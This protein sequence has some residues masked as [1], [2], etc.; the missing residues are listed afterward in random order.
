LKTRLGTYPQNTQNVFCKSILSRTMK[1]VEPVGNDIVSGCVWACVAWTALGAASPGWAQER[2]VPP[3]GQVVLPVAVHS[4]DGVSRDLK[5]AEQAWRRDPRNLDLA[6]RYAREAFQVGMT[7]GD[8]RWFGT[9]K[10]ALLP[11]W[12][13]PVLSAQGHFMRGL[14]KQ[15]FHDFQ[16]GLADINA[17]IA[18]DGNR[19]ELWSWRFAI[20]LLWADMAAA[21]ADCNALAQ[22]AGADEGRACLAV[23]AY[24]TGNAPAAVTELKK[25]VAAPDFQDGMSQDWLRFHLGEAQRTAGQ[26]DAAQATWTE[27]L[28]KRPRT[29]GVRL[30]LVELLNARGQHA[31][32]KRWATTPAPTDALLVQRL[33]ASQ[34]LGDADAPPLARQVDDRMA[35]Q[36][37]RQDALIERPKMVY[38]IQYGRDVAA[39]LDLAQEN[40]AAQKEPPDALLLAQAALKLDRPQAAAPVLDWMTQTGYTDPALAALAGQLKSRLGR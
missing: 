31:Q 29:H 27:H 24:R 21:R 23:L 39:G 12:N 37:L 35:A 7:E 22:R 28:A 19:A 36:T 3:P 13:E 34:A 2:F 32:A 16:G 8:L 11:W 26:Y 10:A 40:W 5:A 30:A 38:L 1:L 6:A 9:A 18:M 4:V 14:V 20:H 15:G 17:A 33:L 25:L